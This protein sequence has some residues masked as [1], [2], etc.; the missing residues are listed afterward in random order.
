[1]AFTFCC[2]F[3]YLLGLSSFFRFP[4]ARVIIVL[5]MAWCFSSIL[6]VS[7]S[8]VSLISNGPADDDTSADNV[9]DNGNVNGN[10]LAGDDISTNNGNGPADDD[11]SATN[12]NGNGN[13]NGPAGGNTSAA[14]LL[15][16]NDSSCS[17]PL[18]RSAGWIYLVPKVWE[19]LLSRL[20]HSATSEKI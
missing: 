5:A 10:G 12:L 16:F 11:T 20:C 19:H 1:M 8:L 18:R 7:S 15:V 9:N 14:N 4:L 3:Q 17:F 6:V 2:H 13:I